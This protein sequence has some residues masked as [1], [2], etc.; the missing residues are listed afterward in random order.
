MSDVRDFG[1]AGDGHADDTEAIRHAIEQGDGLVHFPPGTYIVT[2]PIEFRLDRHGPGAIAGSGGLAKLVMRGAGPALRIVGTHDKNAAPASFRP[3]V[4][5]RER[6]PTVA[7]IAI[8]GEH[9]ESIGIELIGTMQATITGVLIRR[10]K[11]GIRLAR[12]NRNVLIADC[13]LYHGRPGGIGVS[14]DEVNLHQTNIVGSHISYWPHAGIKVQNSEVRNLQI[15]GCDIE[16]NHDVN[17]QESADVWID[18]RENTVREVTIAS[19]TIQALESPGGANVRIEGPELGDSRGAGLWTIAGNILQSQETNLLLRNCRGVAVTGNSFATG[20]ERALKIDRCRVIAVGS[21]SFDHN[22]D[23][24]GE[25][26]DGIEVVGSGGINL[27]GLIVEGCRAGSPESGG[28]IS[29]ADSSDVS[30]VGCQVLDPAHR[31]IELKN[32]RR[33]R[34]SDCT[35][36][37]RRDRPSMEQAIRWTGAGSANLATNNIVGKG[38]SG[39]LEIAGGSATAAGNLV[40]EGRP[41]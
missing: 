19:C 10:T 4:W 26:V 35:V 39:A 6:M 22:P 36:V 30:I 15:T 11:I 13:H 17:A 40:E 16:Y 7:G 24:Q 25:Y 14:F 32:V 29:V 31:G 27:S 38:R 20:F 23:Y 9:D 37:D 41:S 33:T 2:E 8:D 34:V 5:L 1:A 3:E 28:A 12:R 18:A 21:N